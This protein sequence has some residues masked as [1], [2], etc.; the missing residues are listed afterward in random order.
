MIGNRLLM[1]IE[2]PHVADLQKHINLILC[3]TRIVR[4]EENDLK[5]HPEERTPERDLLQSRPGR[6]LGRRTR[7]EAL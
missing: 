1:L 7:H 4:Q 6:N 5:S 2:I 3:A